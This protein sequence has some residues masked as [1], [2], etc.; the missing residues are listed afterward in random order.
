MCVYKTLFAS[1]VTC[2]AHPS[3]LYCDIILQ[4][5]ADL[6]DMS[7][8]EASARHNLYVAEVF[9]TLAQQMCELKMQRM[10]T[11]IPHQNDQDPS[12][13]IPTVDD[14]VQSDSKSSSCTC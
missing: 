12:I 5:F 6:H 3:L 13:R 11:Q 1:P 2:I 9:Y 14:I 10:P 8:I 7:F 4:R